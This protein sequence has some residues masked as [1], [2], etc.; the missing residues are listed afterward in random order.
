ML[1]V[2]DQNQ[3]WTGKERKLFFDGKLEVER[4]APSES[5]T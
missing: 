4:T 1:K 3:N 5:S 2:T